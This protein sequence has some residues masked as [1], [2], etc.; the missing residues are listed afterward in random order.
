VVKA[1]LST[2]VSA[3]AAASWWVL[4]AEGALFLGYGLAQAVLA[5]TVYGVLCLLGAFGVLGRLAVPRRP[6]VLPEH[7]SVA[8]VRAHVPAVARPA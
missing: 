3:L 5:A 2:D 8:D 6:G 7:G 1:W 4:A